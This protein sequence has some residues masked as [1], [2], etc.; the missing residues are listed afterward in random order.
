MTTDKSVIG[1][2][3]TVAAGPADAV[4]SGIGRVLSVLITLEAAAIVLQAA[5]AG[6]FLNGDDGMKSVHAGGAGAVIII[7]LLQLVFA[8]LLWRPK[9]GPGWPALA[10]LL[11][12]VMT[13]VQSAVGG[14]HAL[15]VHVPLGVLTFGVAAALTVWAWQPRR[16]VRG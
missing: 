11:L 6:A 8:I 7:A 9:H 15:G 12:L 13:V 10:S 5:T 3:R 14:E 1:G 2:A 16:G 4:R